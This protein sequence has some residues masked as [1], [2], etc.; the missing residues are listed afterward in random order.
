DIGPE[1]PANNRLRTIREL[2]NTVQTKKL[3]ENAIEAL[4]NSIKDL[5]QPG[6]PSE[7]RQI[8]LHF[9][10]SLIE[11]QLQYLGILRAHFFS[12]IE[13]LSN[14]EDLSQRLELF[15]ALSENGRNLGEFEELAGPLL[16]RMMPDVLASGNMSTFLQLLVQTVKYNAAYLDEDVICGLVKQTCMI[17]NRSRSEENIK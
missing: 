1:S 5:V 3:E 17:P 14:H 13:D 8:A 2:C 6:T 11:G 15:K 4:W 16:L 7:S 10:H 12:V 9:L